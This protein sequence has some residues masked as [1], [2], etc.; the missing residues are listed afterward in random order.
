MKTPHLL[1]Q[2]FGLTGRTAVVAGPYLWLV[3]LF[4]VP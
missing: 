4:L 2:R 1:K 3:L